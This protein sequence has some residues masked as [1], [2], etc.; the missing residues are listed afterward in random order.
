MGT[1]LFLYLLLVALLSLH[2]AH[3]LM[4]ASI[5]WRRRPP[6]ALPA[7]PSE[8]SLRVTVQLPLF[9]ERGV[10]ARLVQAVGRLRWP[11]DR[12]QI[13]ILDDSTDDTLHA[14]AA[15][16]AVLKAAGHTVEIHHRTDRSGFKAGALAAGLLTATGELIAIFDAD[17]VPDPGFLER[18]APHFS[19]PMVGM[20]QARWGHINEDASLLTAVQG[21]MLDGHFCI[22]HAARARLGAW[23]HFNGT[24]GIWRRSCIDGGGGWQHDTLTEDLDLSYRAQMAGWRFV[25]R[26]DEI[27]PAELPEAPGAFCTQQARWARGSVQTLRKLAPRILTGSFPLLVKMEALSHLSANLAWPLGL[28]IAL[29]LPIF[30]ATPADTGTVWSL[31]HLPAFLLSTGTNALYYLSVRP[32]LRAL[33]LLPLVLAAGIGLSVSQT[34]AVWLGLTDGLRGTTG[35]FVRTPKTGSTQGVRALFPL[36]ALIGAGIG[37]WNLLGLWWAVQSRHLGITPF[38]LLFAAGYLWM[39]GLVIKEFLAGLAAPHVQPEP[40]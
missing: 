5:S 35:I 3:R 20:V 18:L 1:F 31:F 22:E 34:R 16:I 38:L 12:L 2:G 30:A 21:W 7:S 37:I 29:L 26:V 25:Y 33:P 19:D 8:G 28:G 24:G 15:A 32:R 40:I 10:A 13:Q 23:F 36:S 4:L 14:A 39:A 17:F 11:K 9:N 6:P 27:V